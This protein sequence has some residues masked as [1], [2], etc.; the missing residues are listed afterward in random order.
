MYHLDSSHVWHVAKSGNNSNSGHAAQYP[1][2]LAND[3]KLTIG[4]A[5]SAASAGDT[6]IVWPGTY[7]ESLTWN[8]CLNFI[9]TNREKCIVKPS[10]G[11]AVTI[12]SEGAGSFFKNLTLEGANSGTTFG[13]NVASGG[14]RI[15]VEDCDIWGRYDGIYNVR[16]YS[17][18]CNC[19]VGSSYDGLMIASGKDI[20]IANC[21]LYTDGSAVPSSALGTALKTASCERVLIINTILKAT[22]AQDGATYDIAGA[23]IQGQVVLENVMISVEHTG[24]GQHK[25]S[26]V[27][28]NAVNA[29]LNCK[30]VAVKVE[31]DSGYGYGIEITSGI[32]MINGALVEVVI[33][34]FFDSV[35]TAQA[36]GFEKTQ[37]IDTTTPQPGNY[38]SD[39]LNEWWL[40]WTSGNNEG[41]T[42]EV[43][44]W[45]TTIDK[46]TFATEFTYNIE[47]GD[48]Y[49]LVKYI[50]RDIKQTDGI[51]RVANCQ[52]DKD[53]VS[54]T[55]ENLDSIADPQ[56]RVD[57]SRFNGSED[58]VLRLNKATK[59]LAN[60]AVQNKLTGTI[61]YY[62]DDGDTVILTHTP[63]D[64]ESAIERNPS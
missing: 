64:G 31:P 25:T 29:Q 4:A 10:S 7:D 33:P 6:I 34:D 59:L 8:K 49:T 46:Y 30:N 9:G 24:S 27:A 52:Y 54:G 55:I 42:K 18:I 17:R 16:D 37:F 20:I 50:K 15:T 2:N 44:D 12:N 47:V 32:A 36:G 45:D 56:G 60:R 43:L 5:I 21:F 53:Y 41:E 19:R 22:M 58:D 51:L 26:G 3:A 57:V 48:E 14:N 23:K 39:Y 63:A 62:D 61:D 38:P 13:I 35:V 1:V 28:I 11:T 40:T